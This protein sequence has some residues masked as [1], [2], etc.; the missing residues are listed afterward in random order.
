MECKKCG[1][2]FSRQLRIGERR[3]NLQNR[4]YCLVCSPFKEHNTKKLEFIPD[5]KD[6]VDK[7]CVSCE[8]NITK[9]SERKGKLCWVC[10]NKKVREEKV[11]KIKGI[12]GNSCWFCGYSKCWKAIEFHH[13]NPEDK[14]FSLSAREM[15]FAWEK[16]E[17]E[18][19][20][21]VL[22]CA[23]CHREIHYGLISY[24]EV[25]KIW[26]KKWDEYNSKNLS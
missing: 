1:S 5:G 15:Q 22:A 18:F 13:V 23:C 25:S 20:K 2:N 3:Y 26:N 11:N 24:D 21:C 8:K 6:L 4:K 14:L 7:K 17:T 9:K 10:A 16:I 12:V 19:K